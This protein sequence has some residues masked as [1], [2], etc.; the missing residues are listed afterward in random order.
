MA[1]FQEQVRMP[2]KKLL[3]EEEK[4]NEKELHFNTREIVRQCLKENTV[5]PGELDLIAVVPFLPKLFL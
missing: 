3:K 4:K 2:D 1:F 5:Y